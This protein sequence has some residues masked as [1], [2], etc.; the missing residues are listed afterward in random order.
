M[1]A[2]KSLL[3][4]LAVL[5]AGVVVFEFGARYGAANVRAF[6]IAGELAFPVN[7]YVQ[8]SDSF[9]AEQLEN[10]AFL[11]D[12][13]IAAGAI[14]RQ[15]WYLSTKAKEALDKVLAYAL[16]VRGDAAIQRFQ[17]SEEELAKM[18]EDHN[19][20]SYNGA[21]TRMAELRDA[22][23]RAKKVLVDDAPAPASGE[24]NTTAQ[25]APSAA[26]ELVEPLVRED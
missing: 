16:A 15:T 22:V 13:R 20:G 8:G 26:E 18:R 7:L 14:H 4:P 10:M 2:L 1:K 23:A 6:G 25:G 17:P 3:L 9:N 21:V 11:I 24:F 5:L 19:E 12:Y